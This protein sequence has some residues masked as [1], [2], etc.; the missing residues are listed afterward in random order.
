MVRDRFSAELDRLGVG[1]SSLGLVAARAA[2]SGACDEWLLALRSYLTQNRD[3]LVDFIKSELPGLRSTLPE[4]TYLAWLDCNAYIKMGRI[5][6]SPQAYFL[7]EARVA[8]EDGTNFGV[9]GEGFVRLNF[10]CPRSVLE[11]GLNRVRN[12]LT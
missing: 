3:Y 8:L 4:A 6:G 7:E 5:N 12:V 11:E 2:Y 10:A 9:V 1:V